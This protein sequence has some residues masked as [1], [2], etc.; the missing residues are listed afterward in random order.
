MLV[1]KAIT[2]VLASTPALDNWEKIPNDVN[3]E[4]YSV[5]NLHFFDDTV[6]LFSPS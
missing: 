6:W 2:P 4:A 5:S 3:E 1:Y